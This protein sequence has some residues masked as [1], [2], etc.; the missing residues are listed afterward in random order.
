MAIAID[1]SICTSASRHFVDIETDSE[2]TRGMTVV[3]RLGVAGDERNRAVWQ[4][5]LDRGPNT[6]VCWTID[7]PR[8]KN[9][10]YQSLSAA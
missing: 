9:L 7:I 3:D 6:I 10:L 4:P 1:P 8:W 2:L 5:L